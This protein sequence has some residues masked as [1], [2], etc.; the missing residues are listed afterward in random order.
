MIAVPATLVKGLR[1][2][3]RALIHSNCRRLQQHLHQALLK[4]RERLVSVA[5]RSRR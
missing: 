2:E 4:A 1:A 3:L 5:G